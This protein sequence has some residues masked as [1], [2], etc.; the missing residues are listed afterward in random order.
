M[1]AMFKPAS[2]RG[3]PPRTKTLHVS[4]AAVLL[5][6][7]SAGSGLAADESDWQGDSHAKARLVAGSARMQGGEKFFRAGVEIRLAP[8]WKTYWRY[9]GDSGVPPHFDFRGSDNVKTVTVSWPAP[10]RIADTEGTTIGYKNGVTFPVLIEPK[11]PRE[12]VTLRMKLDYAI[13]EK[14]CIPVSAEAALDVTGATTDHDARIAAAEARVPRTLEFDGNGPLAITA[15]QRRSESSPARLLVDVRA[16]AGTTPELFVEGPKPD[17]AL[18]IPKPVA[19]ARPGSHRFAFAL[20][21]L[22]SGASRKGAVLKFTAVAGNRA[23][24]T[25]FRLD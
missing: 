8:G 10:Q 21:G 6:A 9:P 22:P 12:A 23:I 14:L 25:R 2:R 19:G 7:V 15:I 3:V 24:E 17:W 13:C 1:V 4:F 18:P 11:N 20:D 5:L 16:P